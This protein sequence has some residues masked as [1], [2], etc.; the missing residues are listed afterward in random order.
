MNK[1]ILIIGFFLL[2][3][4]ANKNFLKDNYYYLSNAFERSGFV[5]YIIYSAVNNKDSIY[6][7]VTEKKYQSPFLKNYE[8]I[9]SGGIY[10]LTLVK[11]DSTFEI[12]SRIDV[13]V[14]DNTGKILYKDNHFLVPLYTSPEIYGEYIKIE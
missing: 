1:I 11:I 9:K 2:S 8:K 14:D 7:V 3:C 10:K 5:D 6:L 12:A 4:N 13:I